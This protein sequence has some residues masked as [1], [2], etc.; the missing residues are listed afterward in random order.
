LILS[1][2][3]P[4]FAADSP[5]AIDYASLKA[6][7]SVIAGEAIEIN[8]RATDDV[9]LDSIGPVASYRSLEYPKLFI[10]FSNCFLTTGD[11]KDGNWKC[12]VPTEKSNPLGKYRLILVLTDTVGQHS[13][14][15]P[16][17][18]WTNIANFE[19]RELTAAEKAAADAANEKLAG[20]KAA[21]DKAAADKAAADK[22]AAD[23]AAADKAAAKPVAKEKT[24]VCLK[25]K[26]SL[27][28]IGK[29]PKCPAGYKVKK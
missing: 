8:F 28:V 7:G 11:R 1:S 15:E 21:S 6:P 5:P 20:D 26:S 22:A 29:N 18:G 10:Y 9:G 4:S 12:K 2:T 27:K 19:M 3:S 14:E 13:I 23:K 24:I 17:S 16:I 25:G